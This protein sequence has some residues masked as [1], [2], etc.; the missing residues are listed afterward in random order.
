MV[1]FHELL[2]LLKLSDLDVA[3]ASTTTFASPR[4]FRKRSLLILSDFIV[5]TRDVTVRLDKHDVQAWR[6]LAGMADFIYLASL[7]RSEGR[8]QDFCRHCLDAH[9]L[10]RRFSIEHSREVDRKY[11]AAIRRR[12]ESASSSPFV[13]LFGGILFGVACVLPTHC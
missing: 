1:T 10:A 4:D 3:V 6:D 13:T 12:Y 7:A 8:Q 9:K 2:T 11:S 5:F